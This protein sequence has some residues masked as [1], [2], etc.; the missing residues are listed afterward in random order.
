M[1]EINKKVSVIVPIYHVEPYIDRCIKSIE[2]QTYENIEIILIDDGSDDKSGSICD[3]HAKKDKRI[4]VIHKANEGAAAARRDGLRAASGE[5]VAFVDGD[6]MI[7]QN[8]VEH[9]VSHIGDTD[10]CTV[11]SRRIEISGDEHFEKDAFEESRYST[12]DEMQT[13]YKFMMYHPWA[14][15]NRGVLPYMCAKLFKKDIASQVMETADLR[16]KYAEDREFLFRYILNCHS[17]VITHEPAY[18]YFI[19]EDSATNLGMKEYLQSL[20]Y[21][22]DSLHKVFLQHEMYHELQFQLENFIWK[23]FKMAPGF[24]RFM[25]ENHNKSFGFP[26]LGEFAGKKV[27]LYGAGRVGVDYY[28]EITD[29]REFQL[30]KWVDKSP[31]KKSYPSIPEITGPQSIRDAEYDAV[32]IALSEKYHEEAEKELIDMGVPKE[33]IFWRKP[34]PCFF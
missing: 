6:D 24:M 2:E 21:F 19:R 3:R 7:A 26:F 11:G 30:V 22:Y 16:I 17:V 20:G 13:I 1:A 18:I 29:I 4:T 8:Y 32:I 5:Y 27:I 34:L 9:L 12:R 10:L 23:R 25:P 14:H 33:K 28:K 15:D 31:E